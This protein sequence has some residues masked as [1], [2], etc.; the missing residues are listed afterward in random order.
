[1][2]TQWRTFGVG[3]S[4]VTFYYIF[5]DHQNQEPFAIIPEITNTPWQDRYQYVL[6][7]Q[8]V[9]GAIASSDFTHGQWL[10]ETQKQ[11]HVSPFF[12][13]NHHYRWY[14]GLPKDTLSMRLENYDD[15]GRIFLATLALKRKNINRANLSRV[16]RHYPF[17]TWKVVWGIY[18]HAFKLWR[19]KIPFY[20]RPPGGTRT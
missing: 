17:M 9:A 12:P 6:T 11:F 14:F 3:F 20:P 1:M 18:W 10:F 19:K 16:L 15:Q 4:P 13:M 2:L 8:P 5:H 7:P